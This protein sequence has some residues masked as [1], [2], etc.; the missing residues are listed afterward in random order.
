M[1]NPSSSSYTKEIPGARKPNKMIE[2]TN[3]RPRTAYHSRFILIIGRRRGKKVGVA[4]GGACSL[5]AVAARWRGRVALR[6]GG[7]GWPR[8]VE[9]TEG[10]CVCQTTQWQRQVR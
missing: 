3:D 6:A 2:A 5:G 8:S 10:H 7:V 4:G 1:K 9:K